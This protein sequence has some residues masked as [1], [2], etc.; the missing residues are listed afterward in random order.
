MYSSRNHLRL[1]GWLALLL[2]ASHGWAA[3]ADDQY[4]VAADHYS[5]S[6]WQLAVEEF[7]AFLREFPEETR[8]R[9]ARFFL[10]ESLVQLQ[11]YSEA[12]QQ[13]LQFLEQAPYHDYR[14]QAQFRA[15]E[16]AFLVGDHETAAREL[17]ALEPSERPEVLD[18]YVLAYRAEIAL[19]AEQVE[20]AE[21]IYRQVI[22]RFPAGPLRS[23]TRFGLART[24][25]LKG[26][27]AEALRFYQFLVENTQGELLDDATLR[28]GILLYKQGRYEEAAKLLAAFDL[29]LALSPFRDEARYWQGMAAL[30]SGAPADAVKIFAAAARIAADNP[31]A[32][33]LQFAWAEALVATADQAAATEHYQKVHQEWP[34]SD[35]ADDALLRLIDRS[36][37]Q[38]QEEA[39]LAYASRFQDAF[40]NSPFADH[41]T[42][43]VGRAALQQRQYSNAVAPFERLVAKQQ[44]ASA[45]DQA[46]RYYLSVALLGAERYAEALQAL[47]GIVVADDK[48]LLHQNVLVAR[49]SAL[50]ALQ[51]YADALESLHRYLEA[52]P[53]GP[54]AAACRAKLVICHAE[55]KEIEPTRA[56][57]EEF[58]RRDAASEVFLPTVSYLA[59]LFARRGESDLARELYTILSADGRP[60]EYLAKGLAGLGK[61]ELTAGRADQSA[62]LFEKLRDATDDPQARARAELLRARALESAEQREAALRVYLA[63]AQQDRLMDEAITATFEAAKLYDQL[64]QDAAAAELLQRLADE[65]PTFPQLDA[66]LYQ[67]AWV[68]RD[69]QEGERAAAVFHRLTQEFDDS[70]YWADAMY[71]MAEQAF[72]SGE[73]E[74]ARQRLKLLLERALQP[75]LR[76]HALYL[77]GQLE[78]AAGHWE[79][80]AEPMQRV[81]AE[82]TDAALR[83][84]AVFWAAEA[85]FRL[86][87]Q[88]AAEALFQSLTDELSASEATW[89]AMVPLRRAQ[90]LARRGH[91]AESLAM[92]EAIAEDFPGFQ[93]QYEADYLRGRCLS[94]L[95]R[96]TEARE[97]FQ[98]V[99][100]SP[101]GSQTETAAMAQWMIGESH[102][103]QKQPAEA[104]RAYYRV[105][106]LYP[107]P[108][109]QAAALLQA[110]KCHE[111]AQQWA[112]AVKLYA[113]LLQEHSETE[114]SDEASR[115][116][117]AAQQRA[118]S[119]RGEG[120]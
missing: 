66:V 100:R 116:L 44:P 2:A 61:L 18:A 101:E 90:I 89:A 57:L 31:L 108:R 13:F 14:R 23:E 50:V 94:S 4:T 20:A 80:V 81:A 82:T 36:F 26:E 51:R 64:G 72:Q 102:L 43:L 55:L 41:V 69:M 8:S 65:Q 76:T 42:R 87:D 105:A 16:A 78:I 12:R 10:G 84:S 62:L 107:Y 47:D 35:W 7:E 3:P 93:Q 40:P 117:T 88:E 97:A 48:S 103:H 49:A 115:R 95:G 1:L 59:D 74:L 98:R 75:H 60:T 17:E 11:R 79:R 53:E 77:Q 22:Q 27:Q 63:I 83:Q 33:A 119:Q 45:S 25:E 104:L 71:R 111:L 6:R 56:A 112:E 120:S 86:D 85:K 5:R 39:F 113:Q 34:N 70:V 37:E 109:W 58:Q 99:I 96:Y 46:D 29:D 52:H 68:L 118:N 15:A 32:P 73:P 24:L 54:D 67:L 92:A 21:Q 28:A 38:G 114:F 106:S 91:W 19:A 110:G 30:D 9:Q